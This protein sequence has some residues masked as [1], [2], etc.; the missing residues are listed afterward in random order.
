[1]INM[2][3]ISIKANAIV[4]NFFKLEERK[5]LHKARTFRL[6]AGREKEKS[7]EQKADEERSE[8]FYDRYQNLRATRVLELRR[9]A[10][11]E[12]LAYAFLRGYD[13]AD[14][15]ETVKANNHPN[16]DE[17]EEIVF[18]FI[19]NEDPRV[20]KHQYEQWVQEAQAYL[21]NTPLIEEKIAA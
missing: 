4:A 10:R 5:N 13:Y 8:T 12:L 7:P 14:I 19:E 1:M 9:K 20:V 3:K 2:L 16:F 15:E 6:T 18:Q 21:T 17:V 11:H